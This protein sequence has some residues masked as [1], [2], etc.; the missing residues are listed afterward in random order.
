MFSESEDE[1]SDDGID[2]QKLLA[3]DSDSD[4][5]SDSSSSS[6]S[7]S[8]SDKKAAPSG[9]VK[10][11]KPEPK[12]KKVAAPKPVRE[13]KPPAEKKPKPPKRSPVAKPRKEKP[14]P[15]PK[16][17]QPTGSASQQPAG[18]TSASPQ[19]VT[20]LEKSKVVPSPSSSSSSS[21]EDEAEVEEDVPKP[22]EKK[23]TT[24]YYGIAKRVQLS[25][26]E[27]VKFLTNLPED[28]AYGAILRSLVR[29]SIGPREDANKTGCV[30]AEV[31]AIEPCAPYKIRRSDNSI[32]EFNA[33]LL[34][35][36]GA[37]EKV[38]SFN[39]ISNQPCTAVEHK[40]WWMV[41][42][43]T[44][45]DPRFLV[46]TMNQKFEDI[47]AA[48]NFQFTEQ[49]VESILE[50]KPV[51]EYDAQKESR[52]RAAV[53]INLTQM[54]ISGLQ[55]SD[56]I[57]IENAYQASLQQ[58][59]VEEFKS[60]DTQEFWFNTRPQQFGIKTINVNNAK[61]QV[62]DDRHALEYAV[63]VEGAIAEAALNPFQRR[64]CRPLI[65]WDTSASALGLE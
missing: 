63:L 5:D 9:Q 53:Q 11:K 65:A 28:V 61:Q 8:D 34:C 60:A 54:D 1:L 52:M 23:D 2:F 46:E 18:E 45:I 21:S 13:K 58:L 41:V 29:V 40:Q 32:T 10:R 49:V 3:Q 16:P 47:D 14:T 27:I 50:K 7:S 12:P 57:D 56:P 30:L 17:S 36:R 6:S 4:S 33:K 26:D 20:S 43:K 42:E 44:G 37:T 38:F 64:A 39:Y 35:R 48:R 31:V 15:T 59:A 24:D 19:A 25:R 22:E 55:E 62:H 51:L